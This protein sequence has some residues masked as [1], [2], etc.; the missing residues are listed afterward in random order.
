M[1][2]DL[3][4]IRVHQAFVILDPDSLWFQRQDRDAVR[5]LRESIAEALGCRL[6]R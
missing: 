1:I 5:R 3:V 6:D 2:Q 4:V